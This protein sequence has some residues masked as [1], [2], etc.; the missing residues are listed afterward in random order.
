[1]AAKIIN[2]LPIIL[3]C[4][5]YITNG[6]CDILNILEKQLMHIPVCELFTD[7]HHNNM[8]SLFAKHSRD[9]SF[10]ITGKQEPH[11]YH[12]INRCN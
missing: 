3:L 2:N 5:I 7:L 1:M 6:K 11:C 9:G 4:I 12:K 8:C 10:Q